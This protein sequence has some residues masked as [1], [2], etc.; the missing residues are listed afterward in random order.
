[1]SKYA[2]GKRAKA[3]CDICGFKCLY[4]DLRYHIFNQRRDG[5][6]VC[7]SCYDI[8][9]P[10]LQVGRMF[11]AEPQA[12]YNPRSSAPELAASRALFS[13]N[14]VLSFTCQVKLGSVTVST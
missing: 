11:H 14:P 12:L 1:M 13:W 5:L 9:N 8:D 3:I 6:R 10:Q 4:K 7:P 2:A